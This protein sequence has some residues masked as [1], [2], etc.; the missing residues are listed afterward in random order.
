MRYRR[1]RDLREDFDYKQKYVAQYLNCAQATYSRIENGDRELSTE[2]LI[3]LSQLYNVSTDYL[4]GLS[5]Y[6][7]RIKHNIE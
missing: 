2:V 4:L 3:K 1:I 5:D 6:P 7:K